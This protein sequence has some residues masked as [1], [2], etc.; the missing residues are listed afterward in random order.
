MGLFQ[1]FVEENFGYNI[2]DVLET[3]ESLFKELLVDTSKHSDLLNVYDAD[4]LQC[5][6]K[7]ILLFQAQEDGI[8]PDDWDI[9]DWFDVDECFS[10]CVPDE[11]TEEQNEQIMKVV[12]AFEDWCGIHLSIQ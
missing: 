2:V 7:S 8:I 10:I 1:D 9:D 5:N 3:Y 4:E 6:L 11:V 12:D